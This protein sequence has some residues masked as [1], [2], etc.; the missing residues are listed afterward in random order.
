MS[1]HSS[2]TAH[3]S[4]RVSPPKY[5]RQRSK[6]RADR[7]Y[8]RI[9]GRKVMLG[10][11]GTEESRQRYAELINR[12][13][14]A[15]V[16]PQQPS[17]DPTVA[18]VLL[19]YL[20]HARGYYA[21]PDGSPGREYEQVCEVGKHVRKVAGAVLV[22]NFGPRL[23]KQVRQ[24]LI[25]DDLSR[26]FINKQIARVVRVFKWAS[27]EELCSVTIYQALKTVE[28]LKKGRTTVRETEPVKPVSDADIE[29]T[30]EHLPQ[31]V[32]D[33]IVVQRRSGMRPGELVQMR[34]CD[35]DRSGDIWTY[36]PSSHKTQH[37]GKQRV[38]AIGQQAQEVLFNYLARDAQMYLFR[39]CDSEEKRRAVLSEQRTTPIDYCGSFFGALLPAVGHCDGLDIVLF[40][41]FLD[42]IQMIGAHVA[43]ADEADA[44]SLVSTNHVGI[45]LCSPTDSGSTYASRAEKATS[46]WSVV[47]CHSNV[48][49]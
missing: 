18:E 41:Q 9:D 19:A 17:A 45:T 3:S 42:R 47:N 16:V 12:P 30:L 14:P 20:K 25:D 7:A 46:R 8:V 29:A 43:S 36:T 40:L 49:F 26:R 5:C 11:Y 44:D 48:P 2:E 33:M 15:D 39:P 13:Q 22:R 37:L 4:R 31:L 34:P 28:G 27:S 23:L 35:I 32:A 24:S 38:I 1:S 21:R 10:T 6:G